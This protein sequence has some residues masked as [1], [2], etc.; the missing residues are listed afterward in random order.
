MKITYY[1]N[2]ME[3]I[4]VIKDDKDEIIKEGIYSLGNCLVDILYGKTIIDNGTV[5]KISDNFKQIISE[6]LILCGDYLNNDVRET[7]EQEFP[8]IF[9]QTFSCKNVFIENKLCRVYFFDDLYSLVCMLITNIYLRKLMYKRCEYCKKMYA[10]R[11]SNSRFCKRIA[12][13]SGKSCGY[14]YLLE[15]MRKR[16]IDNYRKGI[17][18]GNK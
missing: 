1:M 14:A 18:Y 10:T 11:F 2:N 12:T 15:V 6:L 5:E 9:Q 7:I 16:R 17:L 4:L 13:K 3:E 8:F